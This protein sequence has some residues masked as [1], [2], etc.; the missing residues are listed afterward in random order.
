MNTVLEHVNQLCKHVRDTNCQSV[1][2]KKLVRSI[3][4]SCKDYGVD[5]KIITKKDRS[6]ETNQFYVNGYYDAEDDFNQDTPIEIFVYHNFLDTEL[7]LTDQ[8]TDFLIQIYD[9]T[10]HEYRH[11]RQSEARKYETYS[12]HSQTPFDDY[13]ADPD[14]LDAYAMSIAIELLRAM[15]K[16]RAKRYMGRITILAK[17]RQGSN[18]VSPNLKAYIDY[19]GL[20]YLTK[21]LAKKVYKHLDSLDKGQ[22]FM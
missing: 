3:R 1:S 17:M 18:Y 22:I 9:A 10:V 8:I 5:L 11:Q 12:T 4:S 16:E 19:F 20:N 15:S 14:E 13:L 2:F 21:R 6:L 7:F